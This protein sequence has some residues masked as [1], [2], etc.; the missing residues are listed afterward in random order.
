MLCYA[1]YDVDDNDD[2]ADNDDNDDDED[3]DADQHDGDRM[4]CYAMLCCGRRPCWDGLDAMSI[5][6]GFYVML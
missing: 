1:D 4:L 6:G 2:N 3:V 5:V